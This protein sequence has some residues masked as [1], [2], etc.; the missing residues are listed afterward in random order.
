MT[1]PD[2]LGFKKELEELIFPTAFS[3]IVLATLCVVG[4]V[5]SYIPA[6]LIAAGLTYSVAFC[7]VAFIFWGLISELRNLI[8]SRKDV[9]PRF[10]KWIKK[11]ATTTVD[12]YPGSMP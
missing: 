9:F 11:T 5:L 6:A 10:F 12:S 7:L 2:T 8:G 1:K 3:A 4:I